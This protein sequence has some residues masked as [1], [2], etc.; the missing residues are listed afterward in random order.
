M[1]SPLQNNVGWRVRK[2][3]QN[4]VSGLPTLSADEQTLLLSLTRR[5]SEWSKTHDASTPEL[6]KQAIEHLLP[7]V[8]SD[9][10]LEAD[11]DQLQYLTQAAL[12]HL[13][14][15][16]PLDKMLS[17]ADIEEIAVI[18]LSHPI[19]IY[20]RKLGWQRTDCEITTH[21]HL[22]H[23]INKMARP[24]GRRITAQSPRL[25]ALLPDGSRL[26]ASIP[27]LSSG[28][29]TVRLHSATPWSVADLMQNKSTTADA[30][31]F[32]W[33]AF[34][35][36]SSILIAGNTASGK[37]TLLDALFS[38]VPLSER[39]VLIEE[40]PE[41][42]LAHPHR[43]GLIA[44][45]E[46]GISMAELVR[47]SLRM[48][49]DRVAVGEVRTPP[50]AQAFVETLLS[51]QARGSYATFHAQSAP[52]ALRRLR[53]LGANEDDLASLDFIVLQRRIARYNPKTKQQEELRRMLGVW[54]LDK[55]EDG[56]PSTASSSSSNLSL[57]PVF[58]YDSKSDRLAPAP[59]LAPALER[60]ALRLGLTSVHARSLFGERKSYLSRLK[61]SAPEKITDAL[62]KFAYR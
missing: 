23:L 38:F 14:G 48:R 52:E 62:Q 51:G 57:V 25:N 15:F 55:K 45:E 37:T 7:R 8:L 39:V 42:R 4:Y 13:A 19:Y 24:L 26:H 32:L 61:P 6:A 59:G 44:S 60:L 5:F 18:G 17:D 41:L 56:K 49:P 20:K 46:L 34:Q 50:E 43:I 22:T 30:L 11:E 54:M 47:D 28:E 16:A 1:D 3:K 9:E 10:G 35:S 33:L 21:E 29:L 31:A 27:P 58:H 12:A 53:N 40:T 36:D 2:E